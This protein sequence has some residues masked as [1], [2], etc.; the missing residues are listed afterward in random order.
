M[1]CVYSCVYS[2]FR[3]T[4]P[5]NSTDDATGKRR[6]KKPKEDVKRAEDI[7]NYKGN[8][9]I[10][11]LVSFIGG[12]N[13]SS[14]KTK[15]LTAANSEDIPSKTQKSNKKNKDKK[16][17]TPTSGSSSVEEGLAGKEDHSA[18]S[19]TV[20]VESGTSDNMGNSSG[21]TVSVQNSVE[22]GDI[23]GLCPKNEKLN[24]LKEND[25][26]IEVKTEYSVGDISDYC[27]SEQK[28]VNCK[29]I[30]KEKEK[31]S[32]NNKRDSVTSGTG[33]ENNKKKS[34]KSKA[35]KEDKSEM[36]VSK[37]EDT[38]KVDTALANNNT[39]KQKNAKN[40][41]SK[42]ASPPL[43]E[44]SE[45]DKS[46]SGAGDV[47]AQVLSDFPNLDNHFIFTDLDVPEVP[48]EDEF[49]VVEKKKKKAKETHQPQ[50]NFLSSGTNGSGSGK[51]RRL[52]DKRTNSSNSHS[53]SKTSSQVS[54][55]T[56]SVENDAHL[57]DL[58]PSSF[59]ALGSSKTKQ[60]GR[61]N[62]T[63]DVPIP[64]GLKSQDDSDLESVKS[65]PATKGS[66]TADL[67]LSPRLSYARM[68]A[69]PA[70]SKPADSG[71]G[72]HRLSLE[73]SESELDPK[74]A[75]WKGSPTER[76]HSIGS[77]PDKVN[78][79][80]GSNIS[81]AAASIKAGSQEL[82]VADIALKAENT[83]ANVRKPNPWANSDS[84]PIAQKVEKTVTEKENSPSETRVIQIS[85]VQVPSKSADSNSGG[86][87]QSQL[88]SA[89]K[90][91]STNKP[92]DN[93]HSDTEIKNSSS[94]SSKKHSVSISSVHKLEASKQSSKS[95]NGF[96]GRKQKSVIFLDKR[97]EETPGN[98]GISFGFEI[99]NIDEPDLTTAIQPDHPSEKTEFGSNPDPVHSAD[100]SFMSES[101]IDQKDLVNIDQSSPSHKSS[102][103]SVISN[104]AD[105]NKEIQ[106]SVISEPNSD[107]VNKSQI[108]RL[109]GIISCTQ[110]QSENL[111]TCS[112]ESESVKTC[113]DN[114]SNKKDKPE[115]SSGS[116]SVEYIEGAFSGDVV[117][118]GEF[119]ESLQ[120]DVVGP[121]VTNGPT[122]YC[123]RVGFYEREEMKSNFNIMEAVFFL[124]KGMYDYY[125]ISQF[126]Y[127][128]PDRSS[129]CKL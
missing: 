126:Q 33:S 71:D 107:P 85:P 50:N 117:Y 92:V 78:K 58:S 108:V 34:E 59:P 96:N 113:K 72:E 77:S 4:N 5:L 66:Q 27:V 101:S 3:S 100:S 42:P 14:K 109:N 87:S 8:Q 111:K 74:K 123:G 25:K 19:I 45:S 115:V 62:S 81:S 11:E 64:T 88:I 110:G 40:K 16:Q 47:S 1:S 116:E 7:E 98:L 52:E 125:H 10:D 18:Q 63:G 91:T 9:S 54:Y 127:K 23:D 22:N 76:R 75:V 79:N 65:L 29:E 73:M 2:V 84:Q 114:I 61:R 70:S 6:R 35:S 121:S 13:D 99:D 90:A 129:D 32:T 103:I 80:T 24:L 36:P 82:I 15:K 122:R 60:E 28:A 21:K 30:Y 55:Q 128:V 67:A 46:E 124:N 56:A 97:M 105:A 49:T 102:S 94:L 112:E 37:S 17:K 119:V 93:I 120:K 118:Y 83:S 12:Q 106:S 51:S 69:H 38:M 68:A 95:N 104:N 39:V 31:V 44:R 41:K 20:G 53:L 26:K 48:K 43:K 89:S 86:V 57:R